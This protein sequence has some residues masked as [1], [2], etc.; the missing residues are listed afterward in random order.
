MTCEDF[1]QNNKKI[2]LLEDVKTL[3]YDLKSIKTRPLINNYEL[4]Y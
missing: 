1:G 4:I 2:C 3:N